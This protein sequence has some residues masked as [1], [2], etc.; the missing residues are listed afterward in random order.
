MA[1]NP[2][3]AK[4]CPT[5]FSDH[6]Y[7]TAHGVDMSFR[8]WPTTAKG[9]GKSPW[10]IWIHGGGF[11]GGYHQRTVSH[12]STSHGFLKNDLS[13]P[14]WVYTAFRDRGYHLVAMGYRMGPQ[15]GIDEELSD[16]HD[17]YAWCRSHLPSIVD[18]DMERC[19]IAGDSAGGYFST[20]C[21][22]T[23]SPRPKA[24]INLYGPMDLTDKHWWTVSVDADQRLLE[25]RKE[26]FDPNRSEE[27]ME[28]YLADENPGNAMTVLPFWHE[29]EATRDQL[30]AFFGLPDY[31][32]GEK[33]KLVMD[34]YRYA[35]VKRL[36]FPVVFRKAKYTPE[37][38]DSRLRKLSPYLLLDSSPCPPIF[39]LHGAGTRTRPCLSPRASGWRRSSRRRGLRWSIAGVPTEG[40]GSITV[41]R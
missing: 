33:E 19:A 20:Y 15:V 24:V 16:L 21:G 14:P 7:K 4:P 29:L 5:P 39:L 36:S 32:P 28:A 12:L 35:G 38:F 25:L 27:E 13:Q 18:I 37:E 26:F 30:R 11:A 17:G 3:T 8:V 40:T 31:S 6:V 34:V 9:Q 41:Y 23:F 1:N 22:M 2:K 10:L